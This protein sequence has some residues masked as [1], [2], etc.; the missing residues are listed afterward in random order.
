MTMART[1][2]SALLSPGIEAV[3]PARAHALAAIQDK[4]IDFGVFDRAGRCLIALDVAKN[5]PAIGTKALEKTIVHQALAQASL[6][7]AMIAL[8]DKPDDIRAKIAPFLQ[9]TARPQVKTATVTETPEKTRRP[10][11]PARPVRPVAA[12]AAQ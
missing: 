2:L 6:P 5:E 4:Y 1:S 9:A 7:L 3:G 8:T 10:A 12:I 11:R